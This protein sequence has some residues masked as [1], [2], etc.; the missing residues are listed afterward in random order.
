MNASLL[1]ELL[2][3]FVIPMLREGKMAGRKAG[4]ETLH[5]VETY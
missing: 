5:G 4:I 2:P 3:V 1:W